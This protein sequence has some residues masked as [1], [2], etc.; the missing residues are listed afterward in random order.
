MIKKQINIESLKGMKK[1]EKLQARGWTVLYNGFFSESVTMVKGTEKEI[2][3]HF[4]NT[5]TTKRRMNQVSEYYNLG[6]RVYQKDF[7]WYVEIKDLKNNTLTIPFK[8]NKVELYN[9]SCS[10]YKGNI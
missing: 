7:N 10:S 6:F 2:E 9:Y 1:A 5:A 8:S 4:L 3:E